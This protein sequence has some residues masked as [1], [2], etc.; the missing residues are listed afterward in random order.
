MVRVLDAPS[1]TRIPWCDRSVDAINNGVM[2]VHNKSR[3][4]GSLLSA[5]AR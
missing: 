2:D 4:T 3:L 5:S 1:A